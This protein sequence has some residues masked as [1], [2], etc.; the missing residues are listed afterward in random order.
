MR[1]VSL[2]VAA[3]LDLM[4]SGPDEAMDWLLWSK[5]AAMISGESWQGVDTILM[6]RKTYEFAARSGGGGGGDASSMSSY[7]FS[8]TMAEAPAGAELVRDEA[9]PFVRDLK[10]REGGDIAALG[11]GALGSSL[12]EA[13]LVDEIGV[14]IHP[15]LL[16]TGTPL[17]RPMARRIQLERVESRPIDKGCLFVRYRVNSS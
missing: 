8:R 2:S 4:I 11:G 14:N 16:G 17:F 5:D 1:K 13:G 7:I 12:I 15:V 6:G 3:S 10:K 9:T